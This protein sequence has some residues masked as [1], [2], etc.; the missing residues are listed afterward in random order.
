MVKL[1]VAA[2]LFASETVAVNVNCPAPVGVPKIDPLGASESPPGKLPEARDHPYG[3]APPDA[4]KEAEYETPTVPFGRPVVVMA[5]VGL[6]IVMLRFLVELAFA[7]SVT[8]TPK[9]EM[10]AAAGVP[11]I[12]P[13]EFNDRPA[14]KL[15]DAIDHAY[16][17][18]PLVAP[19]DAE[20]PIPTVPFG[21]LLVE[22][23]GAG[24]EI[25]MLRLLD[26]LRFVE[27]VTRTVNVNVPA[28]EGVPE[29]VPLVFRDKPPGKL[30]DSIDH[31]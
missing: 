25:V 13:P 19:T 6:A 5:S 15:P 22:I 24:A 31:E 30:P 8:R 4:P 23:A 18:V 21:R 29:I 9:V 2:E 11:E 28:V 7:E 14:G 20:Y 3:A 17:G 26:A 12:C 1:L 27:S 10:P 16:G